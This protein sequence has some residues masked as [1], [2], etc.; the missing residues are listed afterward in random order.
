[1]TFTGDLVTWRLVNVVRWQADRQPLYHEYV[2]YRFD[3]PRYETQI[4]GLPSAHVYDWTAE[5]AIN[6]QWWAAVL[7]G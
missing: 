3:R 7:G 4:A 6:K 2:T 5:L 1:M